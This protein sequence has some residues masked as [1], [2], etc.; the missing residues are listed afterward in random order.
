MQG[1]ILNYIHSVTT[2]LPL[3]RMDMMDEKAPQGCPAY[4]SV[5]KKKRGFERQKKTRNSSKTAT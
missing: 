3:R 1:Q 5:D 4:A 2:D